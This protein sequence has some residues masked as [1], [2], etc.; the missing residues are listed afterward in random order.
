[1]NQESVR[2][3]RNFRFNEFSRLFAAS[4]Q[5]VERVERV[6]A[7]EFSWPVVNLFSARVGLY[8]ALK[9]Y[10]L[11]AD[12]E[13]LVPEH[14][15]HCVVDV[16]E[17]VCRPSYELSDR[18]R[19]LVPVHQLGYPQRMDEIMEVAKIRNLLVVED[20]AHSLRSKYRGTRI[21][22]FGAASV[23]SFPKVLP[24]ILGGCLVSQD[25]LV[26]DYAARYLR[27]NKSF[28][29]QAYQ[30][31]VL[32]PTLINAEATNP[33]IQRLFACIVEGNWKLFVKLP[34]PTTLV[35]HLL[36]DG[37]RNLDDWSDKRRANLE[38]IKTRLRQDYLDGLEKESEVV[39]FAVPYLCR[40][41]EKVYQAL[42]AL[43]ILAGLSQFDMNRNML[44]PD[45]RLVVALP[46]HHDLS[47]E[48]IEQMLKTLAHV[49][50]RA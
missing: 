31:F 13:V 43:K 2:Y 45:F 17:K 37:L 26:L 29:R 49:E 36:E 12:D 23:F 9:A 35:S 28:W 19:A 47:F 15:S 21:G 5:S 48:Q 24:S 3:V 25:S 32:G 27:D 34:N 42:K 11:S 41:P 4:R 16:I 44:E 6:L 40:K 30:N 7:A 22:F 1:L 46:C 14:I 10:G 38:F 8:L 39:P 20:C 18:T 50:S 33:V